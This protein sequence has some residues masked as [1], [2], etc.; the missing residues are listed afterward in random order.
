MKKINIFLIIGMLILASCEDDTDPLL[1][2]QL[3][4]STPELSELDLYIRENLTYPYNI[5]VNYLFN[6]N[7][8]SQ[9]RFLNPPQLENVQPAVDILLTAWIAPYSEVGGADFVKKIAPRE[10]VLV[11]SFNTNP[12]GT[13]T[14]GLAEAGAKISLFN[15]DF[16]DFSDLNSIKQPLR[17]VQHE[18]GHILNQT[19]PIDPAY[20]NINP[21]DYTAQWFNRS[22]AQAREL[23]YI[24][25][26]ASSSPDEDFV[27]MIAEMLTST[28]AEFD[29]LVDSITNPTAQSIIRLKETYI[30]EYYQK[31]FDIDIYELQEVAHEKALTLVN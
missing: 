5:S 21:G 26:Y 4:T 19:K 24:T 14:L 27:E 11:G 18:Y 8:V 6:Q 1:P 22:D 17:T 20:R 7:F 2:S 29:A 31:N 13:I 30:V 23:G 16:L 10:F 12:S 15:I 9:A 28:R 25:A 3:D